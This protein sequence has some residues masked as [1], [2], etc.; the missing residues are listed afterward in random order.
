M[1]SCLR[2]LLVEDHAPS[3]KVMS[4]LLG[5]R[6]YEVAEA[7][8]VAEARKLAGVRKFDLVVSDIGLPDASGFTLMTELRDKFGL[9]G[10]AVTGCGSESDILQ[11]KAAGFIAH[12]TK[13]V[14]VEFLEATLDAVL[15]SNAFSSKL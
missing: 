11:G 6:G 10:I 15:H 13:P 14:N 12:V 3:R 1:S 9:K 4:F 8:T 2:I 7:G 5:E